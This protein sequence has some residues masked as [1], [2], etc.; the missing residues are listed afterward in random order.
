MNEELKRM[1][2]IYMDAWNK[3]V[4][5]AVL[6]RDERRI[7]ETKLA[8]DLLCRAFDDEETTF[9]WHMSD[10]NR[11]IIA[12]FTDAMWDLFGERLRFLLDGLSIADRIE[13]DPT[14]SGYV[15]ITITFED[16]MKK[17]GNLK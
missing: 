15:R 16:C 2:R 17:I 8:I 9:Q 4:D 10:N 11:D 13:I 6:I 1:F 14:N 12:V 3:D 5:G 7:S